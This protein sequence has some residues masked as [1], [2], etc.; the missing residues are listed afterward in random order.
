MLWNVYRLHGLPSSIVS[1][2][3]SQFISTMWQ[4]LCK[5]LRITASLSTAY[6]PETDGQSERANQDVERGLRTYCNY[7]QDDWAKWLPMV[8]FSENS[9]TSSATSMTP[10]YFSIQIRLTTKQLMNV[11]KPEKPTISPSEW[12][13]F[14]LSAASNWKR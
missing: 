9:N 8:K 1:D 3:G 10:F 14:L 12:K 11:L 6:H 7:M 5:R 2:R 4:S 13:R